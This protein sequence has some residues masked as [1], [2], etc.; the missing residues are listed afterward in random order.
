METLLKFFFGNYEQSG[1]RQMQNVSLRGRR[2][3]EGARKGKRRG[4]GGG[5][6]GDMLI[7]WPK[8]VRQSSSDCTLKSEKTQLK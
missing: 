7:I 3:N 4:G 2:Q 6:G 5:A 1:V 8:N